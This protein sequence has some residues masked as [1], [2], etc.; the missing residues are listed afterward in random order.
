MFHLPSNISSSVQAI[1]R[2]WIAGRPPFQS[3]L[4]K[5]LFQ[6]PLTLHTTR[7]GPNVFLVLSTPRGRRAWRKDGPPGRQDLW[8]M[9]G[10]W[11]WDSVKNA[12]AVLHKTYFV[13]DPASGRKYTD[14]YYSFLRP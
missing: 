7:H 10:V 12:G 8:E 9:H 13:N 3:A 11:K 5:D 4:A 14:F 1:Q 6:P 2:L